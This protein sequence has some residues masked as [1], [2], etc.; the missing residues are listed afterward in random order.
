MKAS[1]IGMMIANISVGIAIYYG[2]PL[3]SFFMF[4]VYLIWFQGGF[5]TL[6][7]VYITEICSIDNAVLVYTS[8]WGAILIFTWTFPFFYYEISYIAFFLFA[9]ASA[10]WFVITYFITE[11]NYGVPKEK[12]KEWFDEEFLIE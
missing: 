6:K 7:W 5:G 1:W 2:S 4:N 11:I 9:T 8:Y 3:V 12:G 10:I